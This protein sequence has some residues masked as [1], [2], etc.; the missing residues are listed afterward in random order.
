MRHFWLGSILL[1]TALSSPAVTLGR[2]SGAAVMGRPLDVRIQ[3]SLAPGESEDS[4]CIRP[5]VF[6]GETLVT[7]VTIGTQRV[8]P[9]ADLSLRIQTS[10]PVNE[11]FVTIHLKAGC[12]APF[13][14]R[15][16]LLAD[17]VTP[18]QVAADA[19]GGA[20]PAA[21]VVSVPSPQASP[22]AEGRPSADVPPTPRRGSAPATGSAEPS[23]PA[24]VVRKPRA[25]APAAASRPRLELEPLDL[26]LNIDR[27][28]VL[29]I[30]PMLLTEPA[31][32]EQARQAA[33]ALWKAINASPEE[34]L[35]E[36][37]RLAALEAETKVL[38]E[39]VSRS[40]E[41]VAALQ[42][43]VD[44]G[45]WFRS[46]SLMLGGALLAVL[47]A[48]VWVWRRNLSRGRAPAW[49]AGDEARTPAD[50]EVPAQKRPIV[51]GPTRLPVSLRARKPVPVDL[52]LSLDEDSAFDQAQVAAAGPG[53][54]AA[55]PLADA[56]LR[57]DF[58]PS[59]TAPGRSVA[60]E[61][62]FDVQ[63][64]ADFFVSLGQHEQAISIL[65]DHLEESHE[66]S[67]L[68]YL[69]LLNIYHSLG[70]RDDYEALREDFN[71]VFNA[72]APPYDQFTQGSRGLESYETAFSRI[73][74]LWPQQKVLDL[75]ERS[76]FRDSQAT[77]GEVFD[78][79]AYR[80]LLFLHAVA[81]EIVQVRKEDDSADG[82]VNDFQHTAMKPLK[83]QPSV[84]VEPSGM[85]VDADRVTEPMQYAPPLSS[86]IGL[87]VDLDA[88]AE[89][90]AFEASLPEITSPVQ[91]SAQTS[92]SQREQSSGLS[93]MLDFE[94]LDF[95]PPANDQP[96]PPKK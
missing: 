70:R 25:P 68:A 20:A 62:L 1:S 76:I 51:K 78:L 48:G 22:V 64:Q 32:D 58:A 4:L 66:P 61:E 81:K 19:S 67:P 46:L 15:Y 53:A 72:G 93:N 14:R 28:P 5:E 74:A 10:V 18:A 9:D 87:D 3:A 54:A 50:G 45:T 95:V 29:R 40:Q 57:R 7:Q 75:I 43:K 13:T 55:K 84:A 92:P 47:V 85:R 73:Q 96:E 89:L 80:E 26:S 11:P 37:R 34:V 79:E 59:G 31:T 27:D 6:F 17:P 38:R 8:T 90:S 36:A 69:D 52:D 44:E 12:A 77:D 16:V 21:P 82:V 83:A 33:V 35:N 94:F 41:Q 56:E 23:K 60:T 88:L 65:K 86:N 42:S 91:P 71:Q 39:Q 49:W 30:S 63:Q 24:S 2:H